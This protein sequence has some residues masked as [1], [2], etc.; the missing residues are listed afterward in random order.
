MFRYTNYQQQAHEL[1]SA[2]TSLLFELNEM[3]IDTAYMEVMCRKLYKFGYINMTGDG[4][5]LEFIANGRRNAK[6]RAEE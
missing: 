6:R 1:A 4:Y 2:A 3:D 5:I